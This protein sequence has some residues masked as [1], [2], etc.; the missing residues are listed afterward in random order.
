MCN[1]G[2]LVFQP[3]SLLK[4]DMSVDITMISIEE[5]ALLSVLSTTETYH[6]Y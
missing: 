1:T 5:K 6:K 2:F 4:K 3:Y